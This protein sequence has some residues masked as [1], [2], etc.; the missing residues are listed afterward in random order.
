MLIMNN[1]IRILL[2]TA[3]LLHLSQT[4]FLSKYK[5][6]Y[7][8][9]QSIHLLVRADDMG[10]SNSVNRACIDSYKNGIARSVEI[11]PSTPWFFQA[12]EMLKDTPEYDAGVHLTLTS[13][14]DLLKWGPLTQSPT[15]V[16]PNGH[17]FPRTGYGD[18]T[19]FLSNHPS[20]AEV[21]NELRAQIELAQEHIP[22]VTHLSAHMGTATANNSL[23]QLVNRLA[24][25]YNLP[26][27]FPTL[28]RVKKPDT[29]KTTTGL[30]REKVFLEI[31]EDLEPGYWLF[32]EHPGYNTHE[33]RGMGHPGYEN[34]AQD[35]TAVTRVFT[36]GRVQEALKKMG[37]ELI[38]YK[39]LIE[40]G[41]K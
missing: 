7:A 18:N 26:I 8:E 15:L 6:C 41:G 4:I 12:V 23:K 25:E 39:D 34:V 20:M 36:S 38:S 16:D 14:W 22:Q 11:M 10:C 40:T 21:E 30:A 17:F 19:G 5:I 2:L 13:E 28:Q 27:E 35:R 33:M 3:F 29:W 1:S 32:V 31:I 9:D 24:K 37:I